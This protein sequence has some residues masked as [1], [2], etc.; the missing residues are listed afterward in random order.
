MIGSFFDKLHKN[1][2]N[3]KNIFVD[4]A[5][6]IRYSENGIIKE[7]EGKEVVIMLNKIKNIIKELLD[8]EIQYSKYGNGKEA[9][10]R[11]IIRDNEEYTLVGLITDPEGAYL[12][13]GDVG[14]TVTRI[15]EGR[16]EDSLVINGERAV[17]AAL[18]ANNIKS[19]NDYH[20]CF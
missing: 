6:R 4:Y 8:K 14:A 18:Y 15:K 10:Y 7:R 17:F 5:N 1:C 3:K 19:E 20:V 13:I 2:C 16:R 9:P 12:Y 11:R